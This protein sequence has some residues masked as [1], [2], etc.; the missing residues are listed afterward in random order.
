[1]HQGVSAL[2]AF[3]FTL[4]A[5]PQAVNGMGHRCHHRRGNPALK[6][7]ICKHILGDLAQSVSEQALER[8]KNEVPRLSE[9]LL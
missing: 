1:M 9:Q 6:C 4:H 3:D 8:A 2:L 5:S 7:P